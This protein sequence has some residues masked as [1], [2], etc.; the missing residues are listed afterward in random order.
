MSSDDHFQARYLS[1]V[2][3]YDLEDDNCEGFNNLLQ[4]LCKNV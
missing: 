2:Y 3:E 4:F 1:F